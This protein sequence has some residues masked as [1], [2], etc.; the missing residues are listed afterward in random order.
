[1]NSFVFNELESL[2]QHVLTE[3]QTLV[4]AGGFSDHERAVSVSSGKKADLFEVFSDQQEAHTRIMLQISDCIKH[5]G[6]S[7]VIIWSPDTDLFIL[8]AHFSCKF[9]IGIWFKTGIN[10]NTRFILV[11]SIS[12]S[13]GHEIS[14]CL[15]PFYALTVCDSTSLKG[16]GKKKVFKVLKRKIKDISKLKKLGD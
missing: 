2:A 6:I 8:S 14:L 15:I 11:H 3:S 4:L 10:T 5:F 16:I 1:M 13:I 7:T 12:Q 9:G